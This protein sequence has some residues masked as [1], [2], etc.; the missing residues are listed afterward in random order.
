MLEPP[1]TKKTHQFWADHLIT[2]AMKSARGGT[3]T[4]PASA[5][6]ITGPI[7]QRVGAALWIPQQDISTSSFYDSLPAEH[8]FTLRYMN[9]SNENLR[10]IVRQT[11][12]AVKNK[13]L[14]VIS[15]PYSL[16]P[17]SGNKLAGRSKYLCEPTSFSFGLGR[18]QRSVT[19]V[20][21]CRELAGQDG[22]PEDN[23]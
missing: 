17:L 8:S 13:Y 14:P 5:L 2:R 20:G 4:A 15:F 22:A 19:A 9:L 12:T 7:S 18:F 23:S 6:E 1:T 16:H 21:S 3:V 10:Q 11:H